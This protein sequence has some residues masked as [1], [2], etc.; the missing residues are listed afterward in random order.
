MYK[1][2]N[3]H[4]ENNSHTQTHIHKHAYNKHTHTHTHT[5]T[6]IPSRRAKENHSSMSTGNS[7]DAF[8]A[9]E[10]PFWNCRPV[11]LFVHKSY[12]CLQKK[13]NIPSRHAKENHGSVSTGGPVSTGGCILD[14]TTQPFRRLGS[15]FRRLGRRATIICNYA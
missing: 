6:H 12:K 4:V 11:M 3:K 2:V 5:H 7:G 10:K 1:H 14:A 15:R 13:H 8:R 9:I